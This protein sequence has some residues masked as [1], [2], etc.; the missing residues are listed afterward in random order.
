MAAALP[1]VHDFE[2]LET[3][4]TK[5]IYR[6]TPNVPLSQ[7]DLFKELL[8]IYQVTA[9]ELRNHLKMNMMIIMRTLSTHYPGIDTIKNGE[10]ISLV[11]LDED[12]PFN[13]DEY[14]ILPGSTPSATGSIKTTESMPLEK[15]VIFWIVDNDIDYSI[16]KEDLKGNTILHYLVKL[17]DIERI[18]KVLIKYPKLTFFDR[19][20]EGIAPIDLITDQ[21]LNLLIF[22]MLFERLN[23]LEKQVVAN[24]DANNNMFNQVVFAHKNTDTMVF[25]IM[26]FVAFL[27]Y[28]VLV[29]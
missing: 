15:E 24:D 20:Q 14:V 29:R 7:F 1:S 4:I 16:T 3:E 25:F 27:F 18:K 13:K 10:N 28:K 17:S 5:V 6:Q 12:K 2:K 23:K 26:I 22:N 9:P 8:D 11:L 21:R 19:N